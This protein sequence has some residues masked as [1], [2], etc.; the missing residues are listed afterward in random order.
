MFLFWNIQVQILS[1]SKSLNLHATSIASLTA[2]IY[3]RGQ[4]HPSL[5]RDEEK[6]LVRQTR[7]APNHTMHVTIT[8]LICGCVKVSSIVTV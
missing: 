1:Y 6:G 2:L 3:D 7:L 5:A 8:K 4:A